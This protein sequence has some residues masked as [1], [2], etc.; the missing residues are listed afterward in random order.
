VVA[1]WIAE[2]QARHLSAR[3][4]RAAA[5]APV[6]PPSVTRDDLVSILGLLG[7]ALTAIAS[8]DP[9]DKADVYASLGLAVSY[10]R[11]ARTAV[12]QCELDNTCG[13]R[14]CRRG[15][16]HSRSTPRRSGQ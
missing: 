10:D 5:A 3:R 7:D 13:K 2:T 15:D 12:A 16:T 4:E 9:A 8:A 1:K 6:A 14:P 11:L